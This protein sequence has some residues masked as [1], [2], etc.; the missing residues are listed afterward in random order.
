MRQ[1]YNPP[2]VASKKPQAS[3]TLLNSSMSPSR[4][5][6]LPPKS[7]YRPDSFSRYLNQQ[8]F[9]NPIRGRALFSRSIHRIIEQ[10]RDKKQRMKNDQQLFSTYEDA[11][12]IFSDLTFMKCVLLKKK[13]LD[14]NSRTWTIEFARQGGLHALLCYLEQTSNR[15]LTLVDAILINETLQCLRA[16]MNISELFEHIASNPQYIDSVAKVLRIPSAEVRM[17]VFEL[18][19]ALCVYSNEGYQLVLHA[20][21]DFQ[22]SDKL[23]NL[24]AVILEQIKSSA[25]S[26]HKWSAIALLNSILSSTEAIER[27]LY[28]RN[29]LIS[30]GIISTL[31][32]A[33][34]DND[35]DLGVQID[36]FFEDKEHDQEE[37]L[38]NF[39]SNDNQ[40]ITQAIQL[41]FTPNSHESAIFL[42]IMQLLYSTLTSSTSDE[43]EKVLQS[44]LQS[45]SNATKHTPEKKLIEQG[46]QTD[47][48]PELNTQVSSTYHEIPNVPIS[49]TVII[50]EQSCQKPSDI[51]SPSI[52]I[53]TS[54]LVNIQL[55]SNESSVS[56]TIP[57]S[58]FSADLQATNSVITP[59]PPPPPPPPNFLGGG[60]PAPPPP[61]GFLGMASPPSLGQLAGN[62]SVTGLS[63]LVDS[64][65]KPK[66]KLRRLQW[67]KLA[68]TILATSSFWMD[69]NRKVDN[70]IDFSQLEDFF[71]VRSEN[72]NTPVTTKAKTTTIL[73]CNR[74]IAINVFLKK[75]NFTEIQSF[76]NVLRDST[77][78]LNSECLRM[79]LKILPADDELILVHDHPR[80]VWAIPEEFIH[81]VGLISFYDFRVRTRILITEF[82]ET[83]ND[84]KRKCEKIIQIVD[85]VQHDMSIKQLAR[86]LLSIGDF[87]NYGSYAGNAFGFR[88]DV[89]NQLQDIRSSENKNLLSVI[90]ESSPECFKF[91]DTLKPMLVDDIQLKLVKLDYADWKKKI[92]DGL[93][94]ID[95]IEDKQIIE[96]YK[97]FYEQSNRKL[98]ISLNPLVNQ[99]ETKEKD[100]MQELGET[101]LSEF[102]YDSCCTVFRQ[103]IEKVEKENKEREK[104][105]ASNK[106]LANSVKLSTK[107]LT[108]TGDNVNKAA[109]NNFMDSLMTELKQKKFTTV[110]ARR[111]R[112]CLDLLNASDREYK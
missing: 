32:K 20:L 30:D 91:I 8:A 82:D 107:K 74:S 67:K 4:N 65:P 75:F 40:S 33:R 99:C 112:A 69:V 2:T 93:K 49:T 39:D 55:P 36:T 16:M 61:P 10:I 77:S 104:R 37:F 72:S 102:N 106:L 29:I 103:L 101:D 23:S 43:R 100:L 22:T 85:F 21:Q 48:M 56:V 108:I 7:S 52:L 18:L 86:S 17:R 3:N 19:T 28:Y 81:E 87:L 46:S 94:Q 6:I 109:D 59:P 45:I 96:Q 51:Q 13:L 26:K 42:T 105:L 1:I 66:G 53:N 11:I 84:F 25:A 47:T 73:S 92:D 95:S 63:V 64:I 62:S 12:S 58:S 27:R 98:E 88:L 89:F 41:Q 14:S 44:L 71:K 68:H 15:G 54:K 9:V 79:L 35:V 38:E 78:N 83:F 111:R 76:V 97:P 90:L 57:T 70:H 31:E 34:D 5:S 80:E 24:F 110:P 50:N 60:P